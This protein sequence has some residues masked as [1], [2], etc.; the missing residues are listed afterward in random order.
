MKTESMTGY[1]GS[2]RV[3]RPPI[4]ENLLQ[5]QGKI[6]VIMENIQELTIPRLG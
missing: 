1:P 2:L 4:D 3:T 6:L 5:L